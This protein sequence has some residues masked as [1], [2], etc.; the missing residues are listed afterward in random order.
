MIIA[1]TYVRSFDV[2]K[3]EILHNDIKLFK[4]SVD[5]DNAEF[6]NSMNN[7]NFNLFRTPTYQLL[8][9]HNYN[10]ELLKNLP[11]FPLEYYVSVLLLVSI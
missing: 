1:C 4:A 8:Y 6:S 3:V 10:V 2:E 9:S 11:N 5:D 7:F